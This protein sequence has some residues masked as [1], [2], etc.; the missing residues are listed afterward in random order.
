L[1]ERDAAPVRVEFA[2]NMVAFYPERMDACF[3]GGD[4]VRSQPGDFY[5][6]WVN[7]WVQ[8]PFKGGPGTAGW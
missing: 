3:V 8:G 2:R 4:P 7:S 5:G 1:L 6:A